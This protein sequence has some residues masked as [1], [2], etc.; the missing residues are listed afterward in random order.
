MASEN[1]IARNA[2]V[3][4]ALVAD[5]G[6]AKRTVTGR[7]PPEIVDIDSE[8]SSSSA[9]TSCPSSPLSS[10]DEL[11]EETEEEED[12]EGEVGGEPPGPPISAEAEAATPIPLGLLPLV[13]VDTGAKSVLLV[14]TAGAAE[15]GGDSAPELPARDAVAVAS[16]MP[17]AIFSET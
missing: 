13:T 12:P 16:A 6:G 7:E 14:G 15:T 3:R 10:E 1:P 4:W 11:R 8:E 9:L 5:P 2:S 17:A